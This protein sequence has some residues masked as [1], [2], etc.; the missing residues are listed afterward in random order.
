[1]I[2]S[3]R[4]DRP[5]CTGVPCV[6]STSGVSRLSSGTPEG[7]MHSTAHMS[8]WLAGIVLPV[9][10]LAQP[11]VEPPAKGKDATYPPAK[12]EKGRC[13][14]QGGVASLISSRTTRTK[15]PASGFAHS[16]ATARCQD[17][18]YSTA[19]SER[20]ACSAHGGV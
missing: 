16:R 18:S 3:P 19:Q 1:M 11:P 4:R 7:R 6:K 15:T 5:P 8:I 13:S 12:S 9:T 10:L 2:S 14:D 20:G 17:G